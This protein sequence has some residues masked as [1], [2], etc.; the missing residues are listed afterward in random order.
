LRHPLWG[1][2]PIEFSSRRFSSFLY[3]TNGRVPSA[4]L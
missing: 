2:D 3:Q 4:I 1:I